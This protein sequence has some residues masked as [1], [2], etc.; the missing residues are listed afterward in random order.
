MDK[1][2]VLFFVIK[3]S[4]DFNLKGEC[5]KKLYK[6]FFILSNGIE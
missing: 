3:F 4:N 5:K 1:K 6:D 2:N